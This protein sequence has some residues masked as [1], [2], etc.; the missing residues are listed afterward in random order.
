MDGERM[1][2][3]AMIAAFSAVVVAIPL[4]TA[5]YAATAVYGTNGNNE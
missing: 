5:A 3:M 2:R 4:A 1:R